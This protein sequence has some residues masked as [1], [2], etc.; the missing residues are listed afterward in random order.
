MTLVRM[1]LDEGSDP[2]GSTPDGWTP[3]HT[4]LYENHVELTR[5]LLERGA[6]VNARVTFGAQHGVTPLHC[7]AWMDRLAV[8]E[9]LVERGAGLSIRDDSHDGTP[10]GWAEYMKSPRVAAYLAGLV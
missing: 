2:N 9:E 8:A 5:M 4:A 10:H 7:A 1:L 6:A 3:L